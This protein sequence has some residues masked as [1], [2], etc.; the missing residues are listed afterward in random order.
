MN[1][2]KEFKK[3]IEEND[4]LIVDKNP[5][6]RSRL[7]KTVSDLGAK[8]HMIHSCASFAEAEE[9]INTKKVGVVLSDY[10]IGG[11]SGFDLFK[12]SRQKNPNKKLCLILVTSNISQSSVA[13]AAEEDV[14]SFIIKPYTVQS[15]EENLMSTILQKICP[16]EYIVKI[17]EGK[18]Q[19]NTGQYKKAILTFQQAMKMH[20][21]PALAHFYIGQAEYL[22]NNTEEAVDS[23]S[24]GI[25]LVNIHFKCLVGLYDILVK[26][27]KYTE[28]YQV[29]KKIAKYFPA[30]PDRL[31]EIIRLS[32]RTC[33]FQDM[34]MY[35]DIFVTLEE[36]EAALINF[37]GAGMYISGKYHL[38]QNSPEQ[39][40]KH[41][42]NIAVSCSQYTKFLR[43]MII[44]LVQYDLVNEAE[45]HLS[46][47]PLN[48]KND[49][50]FLI[51]DYLVSAKKITNHEFIIKCG[52]EL[53]NKKI[54]EV[55]CLEVMLEAMVKAGYKEEKIADYREELNLLSK[56]MKAA[57]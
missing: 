20:P 21:K 54:K 10:F 16:S 7:V 29:V 26:E 11:G 41:F 2:K 31:S 56:E 46:R 6:S 17:E 53:F 43:A 3:F 44:L 57:A 32:V 48:T 12:L 4:V 22:L 15:I 23:Y 52:L 18:D 19:I 49:P 35:Y 45:K 30:N 33:N 27:S 25:S 40:L 14:D 37:M 51:V 50:D 38:M 34:Q 9:I 28:A 13:K 5:S 42:S 1:K 24:D 39:A 8:R 47:F 55:N 36:R